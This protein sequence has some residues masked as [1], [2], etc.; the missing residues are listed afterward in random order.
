MATRKDFNHARRGAATAWLRPGFVRSLLLGASVATGAASTATAADEPVTDK[1]VGVVS[2]TAEPPPTTPTTPLSPP[3]ELLEWVASRVVDPPL[4][5]RLLREAY[6]SEGKNRRE[7][8]QPP[9]GSEAAVASAAEVSAEAARVDE[10]RV[11]E[12]LLR[13]ESPVADDLLSPPDWFS[14][15]A[16]PPIAL[17]NLRVLVAGRLHANR[18]HEEALAWLDGVE[19]AATAAPHLVHYYRA[20]ALHQLVDLDGAR[21][22]AEALLETPERAG[23]RHR[24]LASLIIRDAEGAEPGTP[25]HLAR[26]M[27]DVRRRL[28]L[29][30]TGEP[31]QG[32][33]RRVLDELDKMIKKAE[34][35]RQQQQQQAAG[36]APAAPSKPM[37]DSR[38]AEL[39]G[40]GEVDP[41][42]VAKGGDWGS[43]PP[44]ERDRVTQQIGRDFP[45]YYRDVI[46]AYFRSL[47]AEDAPPEPSDQPP[48]DAPRGAP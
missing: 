29:G 26:T 44:Q 21:E 34:E 7:A 4:S 41:R 27:N 16:A 23:R 37:D 1:P 36:A 15:T 12:L 46:E 31:N 30:R 22:S 2:P 17:A 28:G 24:E 45:S 39:K 35:Q 32:L 8:E 9:A 25:R 5:L 19:P 3:P 13:L 11:G 18:M 43:L 10:P 48:G 40:P 33:Q 47:A 38:P 6:A 20:V 14:E 42:D